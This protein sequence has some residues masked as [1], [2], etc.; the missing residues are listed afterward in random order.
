MADPDEQVRARIRGGDASAADDL[1]ARDHGVAD[2]LA[3]AAAGT[4]TDTAGTTGLAWERLLADARTGAVT[5]SLRAA[6]LGRVVTVLIEQGHLDRTELPSRPFFMPPGDRWAGWWLDDH[7]AWPPGTVL[8]HGQV[9]TALRRVPVGLRVLL[10]LRDAAGL[11]AD[12]TEPVVPRSAAQQA[13][14]LDRARATYLAGFSVPDPGEEPAGQPKDQAAAP[15]DSGAD[16]DGPQAMG[17]SCQDVFGLVGRWHD[18]DMPGPERDSYEQHL[19]FCPPCLAQV[20]N[21][22]T[23]LIALREAATVMAGDGLHGRLRGLIEAGR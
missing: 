14:S 7:A 2:L 17:L 16:P 10:V 18:G 13:A 9:L 6:L 22:R 20:G 11:S 5:A 3:R 15:Q 19:L 4:G 12:E 1:L 21:V 23:A 8:T